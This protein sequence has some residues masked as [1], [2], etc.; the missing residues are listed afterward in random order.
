MTRSNHVFF[1]A[2]VS[3]TMGLIGCGGGG[4]SDR[5]VIT[6]NGGEEMPDVGSGTSGPATLISGV[7]RLFASDR[8]VPV[9]DDGTAMVESTGNGGWNLSI[10]G[11]NVTLADSDRGG[12]PLFGE[13]F[14]FKDLGANQTVVFWSIE[15]GGFDETPA[16][17]FDYLN[18][19][20]FGHSDIVSGA[21]V[22]SPSYTESDFIRTDYI[23]IVHGTP[24][25]DTPTSGSATYEGRMSAFEWAKDSAVFSID[26][27]RYRGEYFM[28]AAFG[29][30]GAVVS[31]AFSN[32][33]RRAPGGSFTSISDIIEFETTA[34]GNHFALS[35]LGIGSE[36]F[37]GYEDVEVRA[38]FFGPAAAEVGGVFEGENPTT[39]LH[40]WFAGTKEE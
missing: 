17:E 29:V 20:A 3:L 16:P 1:A 7:D 2:A 34:D 13:D 38:T 22:L 9:A 37:A 15:G 35:G 18:V 39:I 14:Y 11:N 32:L 4:S 19:Y 10:N 21:D 24:T 33:Q 31:G 23:S 27:T 36:F 5:N 28:R 26:S 6:G 25:H 40:G 30:S 8:T 12:H